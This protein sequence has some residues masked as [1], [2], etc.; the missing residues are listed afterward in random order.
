VGRTKLLDYLFEFLDAYNFGEDN[1]RS[2]S[3]SPQVL[4]LIFEKLNGYKDGSYYTPNTITDYMAKT[5]IE[6]AILAKAKDQAELDYSDFNDFIAN[7]SR[8]EEEQR[9][10]IKEIIKN[11]TILDPAV[12]SGHFL[13][14]ALNVLLKMWYDFKIIFEIIPSNAISNIS[15]NY[16]VEFE[17]NSIKF[18]KNGKPFVYRRG[19]QNQND[20]TQ[21]QNDATQNQYDA[22][23]Q[24]AIFKAKKAIIENNLFGVDLNSKAV[25]IARLRMWIELLENA[26]YKSNG[27]METLPNIDINIHVGD[28]LLAPVLEDLFVNHNQ[29]ADYKSLFKKYQE[30]DNKKERQDIN[31]KL[32]K[33]KDQLIANRS[34][35]YSD[36]IW[37]ID[38]PHILDEEGNFKGFDIIIA[39]PPYIQLRNNDGKLADLYEGLKFEVFER[40]SDIYALF[41]EKAYNLLSDNGIL[42]FITSNKWMRAGYGQSLRRFLKEKTI[43][44]QIIDFGKYEVFPEATVDTN[45]LVALKP[46]SDAIKKDINKINKFKFL[47]VKKDEFADY[48]ENIQ[49]YF[50]EKQQTMQQRDLSEDNFVLADNSILALR[51]K[52]ESVG[53]PLNDWKVNINMGIITGFNEVFIIDDDT[54][55]EILKNCAPNGERERTEEIIKPVLRGR[56]IEK[57]K[58]EYDK[59]WLINLYAGWTKETF[60]G[61]NVNF[62]QAFMTNFPSLYNY[63]MSKKNLTNKEGYN[64]FTRPG[65]GDF[66]WET[67]TGKVVADA[68]EKEKIVWQRVAQKPKFALVSKEFFG[69]NFYCEAT[70]FFI[71]SDLPFYK[72]LLGIFNSK[73]F[74]YTFYKFYMGGGIE[75]EIKGAF[76]GRFPVPLIDT[77]NYYVVSKIE[78]FVNQILETKKNNSNDD[79]SS[80]E[81][82]IDQWVYQLYGLTDEEIKIIEGGN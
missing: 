46:T 25:E 38:F 26:Y 59:K 22:I 13:V 81:R 49:N 14:S 74:E 12:G 48:K 44:K 54:R 72:F 67:V 5:A 16:S 57:W 10:K 78:Y 19:S 71:T 31:D 24:E 65:K 64:I 80:L 73:L 69:E 11:L 56:D 82:E 18:F 27:T 52:I 61:L 33:T 60:K 55:N 79:V 20:A 8:F 62:E 9:K 29:L 66:W 2:S 75:G 21:N 76:I 50:T 51:D 77:L 70:T 4:G 3:I 47:N 35:Q 28:S 42:C 32:K 36:L 58:Y 63:F 30:T 40:S 53:K 68:C 37:N 39:N 45:I 17:G 43:I 1:S 7:F 15:T 34:T 41:I 23:F 6:E